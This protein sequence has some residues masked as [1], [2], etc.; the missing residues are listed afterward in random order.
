MKL[1]SKQCSVR[2]AFKK[3]PSTP[4]LNRGEV[5]GVRV[6]LFSKVHLR[7]ASHQVNIQVNPP[8]P[9][10]P[11]PVPHL[12][13]VSPLSAEDVCKLIHSSSNAACSLDPIPTWL[14]KACL[15]V[16]SPVITR[17]VNL[18]LSNAHVPDEWKTAIVKPLLKKSGLELT[19]K[20]FRP[21][22][23]LPFS[24]KIVEKAVLSQLFPHCE[25]N[26][27]LPKFQSGFRRFYS[28]E[29]ALPKVQ[30]DIVMSMDHKEVT[31]LLLLDLTAAFD[32]IDHG[33]H[34]LYP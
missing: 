31:L 28:I 34:R 2:A 7:T 19:Y 23:N 12:N 15:G 1:P 32:T 29:T 26:A 13:G 33:N 25:Q 27:P 24:S 9:E 4:T 5:G 16:L 20:N 30:G 14:V 21:L 6:I 22:S 18:S 17:M 8:C 10:T 11:A 3:Q